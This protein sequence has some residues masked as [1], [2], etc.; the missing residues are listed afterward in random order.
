MKV[1]KHAPFKSAR[2]ECPCLPRQSCLGGM[3]H[4]FAGSNG[5]STAAPLCPGSSS[6]LNLSLFILVIL[7]RRL[8]LAR[9]IVRLAPAGLQRIVWSRQTRRFTLDSVSSPLLS[10]K[11]PACRVPRQV[12]RIKKCAGGSHAL[13]FLMVA[14]RGSC[15]ASLTAQA[16]S[17][18]TR[19]E[20]CL[21]EDH[22]GTEVRRAHKD[23]G[24]KGRG[25]SRGCKAG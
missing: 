6:A 10:P 13:L 25:Q 4:C 9:R 1:S 21:R 20:G 15:E 14:T 5:T 11:H 22:S 7:K 17:T 19:S 12:L 23:F 18:A 24:I 2:T 16:Q 8:R 3:A